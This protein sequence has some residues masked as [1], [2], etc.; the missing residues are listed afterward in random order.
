MTTPILADTTK[1]FIPFYSQRTLAD[2]HM[3]VKELDDGTAV[4]ARKDRALGVIGTR[5]IRLPDGSPGLV[6]HVTVRID[7]DGGARL[8]PDNVDAPFDSLDLAPAEA[9][10]LLAR[11]LAA[12]REA[13]LVR[14]AFK[15]S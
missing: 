5:G 10:V 15:P 2:M 8:Y 13:G 1:R 14:P 7:S 4:Y 12:L 11:L 6:I 3:L 9:D